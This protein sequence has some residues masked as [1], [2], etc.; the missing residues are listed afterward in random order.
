VGEAYRT[1]RVAF[2]TEEGVAFRTKE[3]ALQI[4]EEVLQ[5]VE[6]V[7]RT[8]GVDLGVALHMDALVVALRMA[9]L[10]VLHMVVLVDRL[11]AV[12]LDIPVD[13]FLLVLVVLT[14]KILF[15]IIF[16]KNIKKA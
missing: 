11:L 13:Q 16:L 8:E 12:V 2:R 6:E 15:Y 9:G 5:I 3:G 10:V 4:V 1:V 7:P 14:L